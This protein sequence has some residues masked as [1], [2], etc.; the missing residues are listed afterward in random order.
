MSLKE[1]KDYIV[2]NMLD[3]EKNNKYFNDRFINQ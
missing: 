2:N 3:K 1:Y